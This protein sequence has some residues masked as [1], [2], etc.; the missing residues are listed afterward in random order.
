MSS[1]DDPKH[2]F[3]VL[4]T[5]AGQV[6]PGYYCVKCTHFWPGPFDSLEVRA[7]TECPF[8]TDTLLTVSPSAAGGTVASPAT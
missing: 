1:L 4:G 5:E 3:V 2:L 6:P 7:G 8:G